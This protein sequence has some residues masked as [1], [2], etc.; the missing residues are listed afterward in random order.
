MNWWWFF[1]KSCLTLAT[2]W[3]VAH[4]VPL[5]KGFP[6]QEFWSGLPLP[7]PGD[8]PNP[9]IEPGFPA[10][11]AD[12]LPTEL[13]G[14]PQLTNYWVLNFTVCVYIYVYTYTH[15]IMCIIYC[16]YICWMCVYIYNF[17]VFYYTY[18]H[19]YNFSSFY[20]FLYFQ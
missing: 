3:T 11:Q 10:L 19:T 5:S 12:S 15:Y 1:A 13:E 8:L 2:S 4:Q 14:S 6:R 7:P 9:V 20:L 17:Q 16:T 18:M